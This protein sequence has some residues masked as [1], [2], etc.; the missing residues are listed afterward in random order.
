MVNDRT[1][2]NLKMT[3]SE[4]KRKRFRVQVGIQ[5]TYSQWLIS[6]SVIFSLILG[7]S[8]T[9]FVIH[10]RTPGSNLVLHG[11]EKGFPSRNVAPDVF[12]LHGVSHTVC[13]QLEGPAFKAEWRLFVFELSPFTSWLCSPPMNIKLLHFKKG[14]GSVI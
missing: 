13:S 14:V 5:K 3:F 8:D 7:H 6:V 4:C 11:Q 2:N 9:F 12:N 10:M 1:L